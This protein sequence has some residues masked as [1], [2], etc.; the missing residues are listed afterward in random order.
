LK[1]TIP[2]G[3]TPYSV[4]VR[5]HLF[6]IT[7]GLHRQGRRVSEL[8]IEFMDYFLFPRTV[9]LNVSTLVYYS[10]NATGSPSYV[11]RALIKL[12]W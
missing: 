10:T 11:Q 3:V 12:I 6:A 5:Y 8:G 7:G 1:I 2:W 4:V 9:K